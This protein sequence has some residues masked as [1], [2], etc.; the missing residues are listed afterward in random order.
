MTL[1]QYI[2]TPAIQQHANSSQLDSCPQSV[3]ETWPQRCLQQA[4][5]IGLKELCN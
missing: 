5:G 3:A 1:Q 4:D 2:T